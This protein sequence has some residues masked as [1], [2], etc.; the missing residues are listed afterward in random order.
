MIEI[1]HLD[2]NVVEHCNFGCA[3]CSHLSPLHK[4]WSMTLEEIERDL[5]AL[6]PI[7]H[8]R[9]VNIVGGEPTL[10]KEIIEI[11]RLL[12]RIR[13]DDQTH[14]ITNG[15]MLRYMTEDFWKEIE[16]LKVSIYARMEQST[17]DLVAQKSQQYGFGV[18]ASEFKEFFRQFKSVPD[19]GV[20]SFKKC[21]WKSDCFSVH[22]GYFY[23]CPQATFFLSTLGGMKS[24]VDGLSLEG[25]TEE[26]LN[27]YM[28]R[29][30][31]FV[32]CRACAAADL[33][34]HPWQEF[35]RK[36]WFVNSKAL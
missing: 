35:K 15:S 25:I 30:K 31:P 1:V 11:M 32:A 2:V 5:T 20:E 14:L 26:A 33:S 27:D 12:K 34:L 24:T 29:E 13:I 21:P 28:H 17:M 10:H 6:K 36:D 22:R 7:L 3:N 9:N 19:D 23:L 18:E 4:P 16:F 8:P